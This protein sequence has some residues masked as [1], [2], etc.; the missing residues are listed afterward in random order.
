MPAESKVHISV[1]VYRGEPLDYP[2]YRHTALWIRFRDDESFPYLAHIVGSPRDYK[3]E[4]RQSE[5][6]TRSL[7][8]ARLISVGWLSATWTPSVLEQLFP[9]IPINNRDIE[10]NC[11][12]WVERALKLLRDSAALTPAE[13]DLGVNGMVDAIAE[14]E[15]EE[16]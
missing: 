3:F 1:V 5:D 14:A 13:Y 12:T 6:P 16:F 10:F 7:L 15:D 4:T 11:Q 8:F 9:S 2:H